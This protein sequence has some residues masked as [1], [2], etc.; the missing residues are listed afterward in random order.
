M[1][2]RSRHELS[3]KL[4]RAEQQE[5]TLQQSLNKYQTLS[6]EL[7]GRK[8]EIIDKAKGEAQN[9]LKE[10][11]REIEKTIRHIRE[12]KAEKKETLKVRNNLK[13]LS[14]KVA[15][16]AFIKEKKKEEIKEGDYVRIIGQD[17]RGLV[18]SLKGNSAVVQF[19]EMS[20]NV[21][22]TKLEKS[23]GITTRE[24]TTKLRSA[25]IN[26][27]EKQA[28][29]SS[30]LDV[31]GKRVD[32]VIPLLEQFMDTAIL[33]A[34]GELKILHGK[35]EGVLRKVIR[36]HLKKIRGVASFA[37]EHI[38]RGGDGITIVVLK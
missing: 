35:G 1:L 38:E 7:E 10:T 27:I 22:V 11:N 8:K 19:G 29:F 37:D 31:R 30:T 18:L 14:S 15:K 3:V 25:G 21:N 9:L 2:F 24:V 12:N 32:E 28:N 13:D 6:T 5:S 4:K 26:V 16:D 36:E 17:G 23:T 20:S 33:L 34:Q